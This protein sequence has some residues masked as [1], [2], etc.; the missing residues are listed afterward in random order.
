[1]IFAVA[2]LVLAVANFRELRTETVRKVLEA[3]AT[4]PYGPPKQCF[5]AHFGLHVPAKS[6]PGTSL[7]PFSDSFLLGTWVNKGKRKGRG[8]FYTAALS[9]VIYEPGLAN[10][11]CSS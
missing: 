4:K 2:W 1:V 3:P 10:I 6:T 5:L 7:A 11:Y 8:F 9:K